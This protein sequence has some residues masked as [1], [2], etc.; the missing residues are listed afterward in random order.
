MENENLIIL[1]QYP[2]AFNLKSLSP[3]CLK[4]EYLL[5]FANIPYQVQVEINP[6]LGPKGKM[7]YIENK[8]SG[9]VIADSTFIVDYLSN[10][11]NLHQLEIKNASSQATALAFKLMIEESLYFV[12]LASRWYDPKGFSVINDAFTHMF[13]LNSGRFI[14]KILRYRLIKQG[15]AQGMCRHNLAE[16]YQLGA[17]QIL[18]LS[19]F[20]GDQ[21]YFFEDKIT[22]FDFTCF[23]FLKTIY[24]WPVDNPLKYALNS[25]PNLIAYLERL[26]SIFN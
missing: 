22:E 16:I 15:K 6:M 7:P 14:L 1:H 12:I 20:L 17:K 24:S 19:S 3:F 9:D 10:K 25:S 4:V 2:G 8:N 21:E 5:K 23:S 26:E 11:F 18:S 13:P